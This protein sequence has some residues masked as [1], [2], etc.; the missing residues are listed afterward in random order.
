MDVLADRVNHA[1]FVTVNGRYL[2]SFSDAPTSPAPAAVA[3]GPAEIG[4][5]T[6]GGLAPF[7]ARIQA[8][9]PQVRYCQRMRQL[10]G[11]A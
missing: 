1:L 2:L 8:L 7:P 5:V 6:T 9:P 10:A 4:R 3:P 11:D